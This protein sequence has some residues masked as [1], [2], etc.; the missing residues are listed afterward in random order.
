[1]SDL[2]V[3][4]HQI[5]GAVS[6]K[7]VDGKTFLIVPVVAV[8]EGVLHDELAPASE[9]GRA[10]SLWEDAPVPVFHPQING[11]HVSAR[12]PDQAARSIGRFYDVRM[13][14]GALKGNIWLDIARAKEIGG[15][16]LLALTMLQSGR[17]VDVS[18]AYFRDRETSAGT[19]NGK[20]YTGIQRNIQPDHLALL[21]G[22]KGE[23]SWKDGCGAPRVNERGE[24]M[25]VNEM[26]A[27]LRANFAMSLGE[28]QQRVEDAW[29]ARYQP[30]RSDDAPE[31]AM[32]QS[33]AWVQSVW[34]D[35]VI[36]RKGGEFFSYPYT[37]AD[38]G[39][40]EFAEPVKVYQVFLPVGGEPAT[41]QSP[42]SVPATNDGGTKT[43]SES[44]K[45][46][47]CN[48]C[49]DAPATNEQT[50]PTTPDLPPEIAQVIA[51]VQEFGGVDGMK[52]ALASLTAN[53]KAEKETLIAGLTANSACAFSD[54]DLAAM[55]TDQL[56]KLEVSLRPANYRGNGMARNA[57][58]KS[59]WAPYVVPE[60]KAVK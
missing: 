20:S 32:E 48:D 4:R 15:D 21:P 22:G 41:N 49:P 6:E 51:M 38:D 25:Q 59:E 5:D 60:V 27:A 53:Q 50:P 30:P 37:L 29:Y 26:I 8:R 13:E 28:Q 14:D 2:I 44:T 9:F 19:F 1:M 23:C 16:A 54:T 3:L 11:Q 57:A 34:P 58:G 40:V 18:T 36:V 12:R 55:T 42:A 45:P 7:T 17:P 47:G 10:A 56:R 39:T 33:W 43:M 46:D 35:D 31:P 52:A 24:R